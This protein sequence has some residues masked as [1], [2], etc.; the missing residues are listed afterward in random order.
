ME[1]RL[2][3]ARTIAGKYNIQLNTN[4]LERLASIMEYKE[5]AKG[6]VY[7]EQGQIA[8]ELIYVHSGMIRQFYY[9][10]GHDITEHFT[11]EGATLAY[12]IVSLFTGRPTDL[13]IEA[14]E[15]T[16]IYTISNDALHALSLQYPG[17]TGFHIRILE[18]SLVVSQQKADSWR[19][20]T[21]RERYERFV[22][23]IRR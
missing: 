14:L 12:C 1:S 10:K 13:L 3:I 23:S 5:L 9:K 21:A 6:E 7:L 19:F 17:I 11:C 8:R 16:V 22:K 20:E 4:D 18:D 15:P 2:E